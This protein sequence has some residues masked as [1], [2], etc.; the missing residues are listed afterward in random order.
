MHT[1]G[2]HY[3]HRANTLDVEILL[4]GPEEPTTGRNGQRTD[5]THRELPGRRLPRFAL[6][7]VLGPQST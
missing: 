1:N 4:G 5:S 2:H 6:E 3:H 7:A